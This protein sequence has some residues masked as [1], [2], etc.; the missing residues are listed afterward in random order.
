MRSIEFAKSKNWN[1]F[2]LETDPKL[3]VQA[4]SNQDIVPWQL[5]NMWSNCIITV[6]NMNFIISHI[7]REGNACADAFANIGLT[8]NAFVY[9][10]SLPI[11]IR[12]DYVK[13]RLG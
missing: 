4:F 2:W 12:S 10:Y 7:Y 11:Q 3:V 1:S 6:S 5:R 8:L 9:Y 13:N